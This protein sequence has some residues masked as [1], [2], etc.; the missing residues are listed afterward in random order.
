MDVKKLAVKLHKQFAHPPSSRLA[1]LVNSAGEPWSSND[2]L[3]EAIKHVDINCDTCKLFK[4]PPPRPVVGLPMATKFLECIAMDLKIYQGH[5]LL[6]M[7]DYVTRA[8]FSSVVRS[9]KPE[10]IIEKIFMHL[11]SPFGTVGE[12]FTDNGGEFANKDFLNMCE[13]LNIK[14]RVTAG[15]SPWSNGLV[16]RHNLI[17]SEMLDSILEDNNINIHIGLAWALNAKNSL[18][19]CHGFSPYQL[20]VGSNPK[21]PCAFSDLPPALTHDATSKIIKQNLDAL[22]RAREAFIR[23]ENSERIRRALRNNIRSANVNTYFT[24]DLVYYKRNDNRKWHGP[25]TVIGRDGCQ[26]L[27]KHGSYYVRVHTCRVIPA[28]TPQGSQHESNM[29]PREESSE[30]TESIQTST[31]GDDSG[32]GSGNGISNSSRNQIGEK[33]PRD[34]DSDDSDYED[35]NAHD[36]SRNQ[37]GKKNL[38]VSNSR[39]ETTTNTTEEPRT[40]SSELP[41]MRA[42]ANESNV[43]HHEMQDSISELCDQLA[44]SFNGEAGAHPSKLIDAGRGTL[45]GIGTGVIEGSEN[46]Q[47]GGAC[48]FEPGFSNFQAGTRNKIRRHENTSQPSSNDDN[49][50]TFAHGEPCSSDLSAIKKGSVVQFRGQDDNDDWYECEIMSRAGRV[51]GKYPHSWNIKRDGTLENIDF[52]RD[53]GD[54]R[55]VNKDNTLLPETTTS[56]SQ[57]IAH[58]TV[59]NEC[60]DIIDVSAIYTAVHDQEAIQAKEKELQSWRTEEVY[61]EVPDEGQQTMNTTWVIKP[62]FVDGRYT[63]KAR[64]C[65]RGFEENQFF[66]TD[67][68]TCSREGIRIT[69]TTISTNGW[70]LRSLDVKTAFL[71]GNPM[72]REVFLKPPKEA[73]TNN[74]WLLRKCV[75]ELSDASRQW[76]LRVKEELTRLGGE[77]NKLDYGLFTFSVDGKLCGIVTCFVDD[78]IYG[79]TDDFESF[80]TTNLKATFQIGTEND[81][82][83]NYV[84]LKVQQHD[85]KSITIDQSGYI[86]TIHHLEFDLK[87]DVDS[88]L[89][90][91]EI[92]MFRGLVGKL[93]WACG[94][95]CPEISF[96]V[97]WAS[98]IMKSPTIR[99]A[100]RLNKVVSYLRG[101][102]SIVHFPRLETNTIQVTTYSDASFNNLPNGGSQGGHLVFAIDGIGNSCPI[103]WSSTKIKR[104]VR[105]SLAAETLS[106]ADSI[107]TGTYVTELLK[108]ILPKAVERPIKAITDS[109]SIYDNVSTSHRVTDKGLAIDMNLIREQIDGGSVVLEWV[110]GI[111]QL[112]NVLTKK[113]ASPA[114]LKRTLKRGFIEKQM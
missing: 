107:S 51:T 77:M 64:L 73:N 96:E 48:I 89:T 60:D 23:A 91:K 30:S 52:E 18:Q 44:K 110:D 85:D 53:V 17:I 67:S 28:R 7:I 99:D 103:S 4:R 45:S 40:S 22:H 108:G 5:I 36:I 13:A 68:P 10:V 112:S 93:N 71:Q 31:N 57:E 61:T 114:S 42:T 29:K 37:V 58:L 98:T 76:Y 74:L 81:V 26:V 14:V 97:C 100:R 79:G 43:S 70:T 59:D 92:T 75:Y 113:N 106:L 25:G 35:S 19:N 56:E 3:K 41:Q 63:L 38:Q 24:G 102:D 1:K 47:R 12:F 66:R 54:L 62:K 8:S 104:V 86:S 72:Q 105:S 15:E 78:M 27:I 9:K 109:K 65:A 11:I 33:S 2:A 49:R 32:Y 55:I 94:M 80:I 82:S 95:T 34:N 39:M 88:T 87:R 84:G 111:N 50:P 6:H 16:E 46:N 101:A 83:F 69:L 90:S 21:L 20:S